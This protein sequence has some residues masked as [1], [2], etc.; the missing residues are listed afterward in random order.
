MLGHDA[1]ILLDTKTGQNWYSGDAVENDKFTYDKEGNLK[2]RGTF[3]NLTWQP[4]PF[5]KWASGHYEP[6]TDKIEPGRGA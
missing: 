3:K 5:A 4:N 6:R 2:N 1:V